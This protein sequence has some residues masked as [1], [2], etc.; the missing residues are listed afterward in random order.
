MK[1]PEENKIWLLY[2]PDDGVEEGHPLLSSIISEAANKVIDQED[3][4]NVYV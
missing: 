4:S 1:V 3:V 2:M